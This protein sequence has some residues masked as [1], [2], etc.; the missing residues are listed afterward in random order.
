MSDSTVAWRLRSRLSG[1]A[2][3]TDVGI[4]PAALG[5]SRLGCQRAQGRRGRRARE[6]G[7]NAAQAHD[8]DPLHTPGEQA[9]T[10]KIG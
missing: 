6:A 4:D 5:T 9:G 3:K 1:V 2:P 10:D 8:D 7:S